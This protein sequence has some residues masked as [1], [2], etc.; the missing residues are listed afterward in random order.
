MGFHTLVA[1][2]LVGSEGLVVAVEPQPYNCHKILRNLIINDYDNIHLRVAAAG[3]QDENISLQAQSNS[4]FARLSVQPNGVNNLPQV[5]NVPMLQLDTLFNQLKLG[6][7]KLLKIDVENFELEVL[8]GVL[9]NL[10]AIENIIL[11]ILTPIDRF[12]NKEKEICKLLRDNS[13][14]LKT[15]SNE[16]LEKAKSLPEFN[17]LACKNIA[18]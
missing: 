11:E 18:S 8:Q 15:I 14:E 2:Q 3:N 1:R 16:P 5:F 12:S 7:I 4:D 17:L 9:N 13:F 10:G 6:K